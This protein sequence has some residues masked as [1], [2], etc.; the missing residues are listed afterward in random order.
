MV[1][2]YYCLFIKISYT[3]QPTSVPN[4]MLVV[5]SSGFSVTLLQVFIQRELSFVSIMTFNAIIIHI[6]PCLCLYSYWIMMIYLETRIIVP[7][8]KS[9]MI[10]SG[11]CQPHKTQSH[12][13]YRP[14][15]MSLGYSCLFSLWEDPPTVHSTFFWLGSQTV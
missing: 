12:M 11:N 8:F 1:L 15:V 13:G 2:Y 5:S 10:V 6:F 14:L 4:T 7:K 9:C 3:W